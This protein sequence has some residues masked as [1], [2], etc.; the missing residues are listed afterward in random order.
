MAPKKH[1]GKKKV[2]SSNEGDKNS[3]AGDNVQSGNASDNVQSGNASDN[4]QSGNAGDKNVQRKHGGKKKVQSSNE[5]DK[6]SNASDNVQSGNA[7]D[8][9]QSGNAGDKNVQR[10]HGGKKKVQSSS[11][12]DSKVVKKIT[13]E[14]KKEII[15]KHDR[16]IR[17]TDLASEYKMAKS[18][19]STILKNKAAIKGAD[20]AKGVTMLTKQRTQVLE[21]VEKL[22]LVW[23]NEKQQA[24]DSVS[25]AMICEKA[26]KLHSDLLQRSPSTSAA[27]DEFKASRG[28]FEKF[29][30]RS[31]IHSVIR[32]GEAS[33]S[34][35]AAAEAYKL[36]FAEFMK[37]E[38]YVPQQVFNCD[39]TGLFWKKMPNRTYITQEEKALPGHKPMKDR[40]TLLLCANASAN[41]KIKPLLVYHSQTPRAFRQQNV[42]K[43]RLPVMWRANA[44]A[45]VTRQLFME[46]LHEVFAPTV[47]KYLSDNQLP[48]RCLLLMDNAPA[49]PP[50]LVDDMDA[51]YDF[52]KVKFLPPN[53]TPL[54]QPMDQQV[55]CNFKKLYTKALFTRC[56]NVT[57][58]TSL[59][60]KDFWK[61]HFN[62]VH[63]INLIDKAWEE[64]V[65]EIVSMGK[66]MGLDVDGADVE[67]LVKEHREELT[68]EELSELHSEQ[69]KALLEEHS[70][71]EEEEREEV[72]SDA[73]KSIMQKWNECH[74]FFE[75]HH[76][77]ITVVN[78]VLN[79]M[80]DNVVSHFRRVM[81][82]R[83]R[84]VTLDRFFRKTEPAARRQRREETPEGD[85]PDVLMEGDSPSKQ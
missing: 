72:S 9:V 48:E 79:L 61:K 70:T 44:K 52:I 71:E 25:E 15:E 54:L 32:H 85:P 16:G 62:V 59:T 13:I 33:S 18:T 4:V 26:R 31:G 46:W 6:N 57:E 5:G 22:L 20:V 37:T 47:R 36:D 24:G 50:A 58:E 84:Q 17:V 42:N 65:E 82:H 76:P 81:Q 68:T 12:G 55:I 21:E 2:R 49:H 40:L 29:R 35:K 53:T 73:I 69:Q 1:S 7:S 39:E 41:L 78:R 66:S 28:W 45:W 11:K 19:I 27:S 38:G 8:N 14:L 75:K 80:N 83:K 34:D 30:R 74:D 3:N 77:N 60:L 51:E 64:V 67:E 23:L 10:K 43:A 56:F 63:C